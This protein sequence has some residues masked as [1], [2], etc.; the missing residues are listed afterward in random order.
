M[1]LIH[2]A[3]LGTTLLCCGVSCSDGQTSASGQVATPLW[4]SVV[5]KQLD[6]FQE[7]GLP[8]ITQEDQD[9]VLDLLD[10]AISTDKGRRQAYQ[11]FADAEP[12][13]L[14]SVMLSLVE[15]RDAETELKAEAY[16]WLNQNG[17]EAMVPRLSLRLKYEKDWSANVDIAMG[18]LRF[19]SGAGLD[20]LINILR[21][22]E[23]VEDLDRARWSAIA[24]LQN[25]PPTSGWNPG[26]NFDDDWHRLI[27]VEDI[28]LKTHLLPGFE[29]THEPSRAYRAEVWRTLAKLQ[30]QRLRPV[31]DA[32]FV[33][34]RQPTWAFEAVV[35]TAYDEDWYVREHALQTIAWIGAPI[36]FWA[37]RTG[38]ALE[39]KLAP[40]LGDGRLRGRV[41]EAMGA[42]GMPIMQDA[43]LLWLREGNLEE[44]TAAADALLRCANQDIL[45]PIEA[46]LA[47]KPYLSPEGTYALECL[48]KSL[49]KNHTLQ[50]PQGLDPS[51]I[52]RRD[53]WAA[54]R[55]IDS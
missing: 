19:G 24:S 37:E 43:I 48:R 44:S 52:A 25:L 9:E 31:D 1:K 32:R 6:V 2:L 20:S 13:W 46:F 47:S 7:E 38:F 29:D 53:R 16:A 11:V 35:K 23:G 26:E 34:M 54:Q 27:E 3:C 22:E 45:R 12:D 55:A 17:I 28:W 40:L 49:E 21:T 15:G 50:V 42:S 4:D 10:L 51:E 36:G 41:L 18:L 5:Q 33:L 30:S 39:P 14:T 8:L